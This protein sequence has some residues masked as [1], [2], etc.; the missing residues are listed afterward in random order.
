MCSD[1]VKFSENYDGYLQSKYH[2]VSES[3]VVYGFI[4]F[5]IDNKLLVIIKQPKR[6]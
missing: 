5:L 3:W 4:C 1:I 6:E 2:I